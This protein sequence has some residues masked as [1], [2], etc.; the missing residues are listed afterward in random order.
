MG[1]LTN[2]DFKGVKK[3]GSGM[4]T[5]YS[6]IPIPPE[7]LSETIKE[8]LECSKVRLEA[9]YEGKDPWT[10]LE[11]PEGVNLSTGETLPG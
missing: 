10:D 1:D 4:E 6:V 7:S 8:A 9:L 2:Y 3:T 11:A 5:N